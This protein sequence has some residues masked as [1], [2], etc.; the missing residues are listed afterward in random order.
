MNLPLVETK[1][2]NCL[3]WRPFERRGQESA[4]VRQPAGAREERQTLLERSGRQENAT[5]VAVEIAHEFLQT[6][7]GRSGL[8]AEPRGNGWLECFGKHFIGSVRRRGEIVHLVAHAEQKVIRRLELPAF[9][10]GNELALLH[11]L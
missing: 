3:R 5:H 10:G 11:F 6:P 4:E 9:S 2:V 1:S 8:V 7:A